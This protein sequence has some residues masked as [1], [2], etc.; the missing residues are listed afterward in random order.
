MYDYNHKL[1]PVARMLRNNATPQ[2]NQL[3]YRYLRTFRPKFQRQKVLLDF[4][5][6][7][8]CAKAKLV[9]EIDGSQHFTEEGEL[10]DADR[11]EIIE[12]LGVKVIRFTNIE[13]DKHLESVCEEIERTVNERI[14]ELSGQ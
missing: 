9:V 7:F 3:W 10:H 12:T 13:I 6:D 11:T 8:Y 2:E 14:K 4:I 5:A 1:T